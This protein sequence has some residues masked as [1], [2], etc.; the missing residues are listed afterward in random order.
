MEMYI[1]KDLRKNDPRAPNQKLRSLSIDKSWNGQ[2]VG[3]PTPT[4]GLNVCILPKT[5]TLQL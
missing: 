3:D 1:P 4:H 2:N 5:H